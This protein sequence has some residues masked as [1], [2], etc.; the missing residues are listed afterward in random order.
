MRHEPPIYFDALSHIFGAGHRP[1]TKPPVVP[2]D[3][4]AVPVHIVAWGPDG[5][6]TTTSSRLVLDDG[7]GYDG[8]QVGPQVH[9]LL[10]PGSQYGWGAR[11]LLKAPEM[12]DFDQ[13]IAL[14]P[15]LNV[16][17]QP[18][19]VPLP[20]L[21]R[22]GQFYYQQGRPFTVIM[23]SAFRLFERLL[24]GEDIDPFLA[25]L[26]GEGFNSARIW[27]LNTSVGHIVPSEHAD[28]YQRIPEL[29]D[30]CAKRGIYPELTVFTQTRSLMPALGQQQDH[31]DQ[32][33]TALGPRFV[34]VEGV[35]ENDQ[36]DN[37]I[38]PSLRFWKPAGATFDLCRGS[39]GSDAWAVEPVLDSARYHSNDAN[40]WWR[41]QAHNPM[42]IANAFH[43]PCIANENTRPDHDS[44][45]HH[46][47]D[48]AAG[49]ALLHAGSCFHSQ[50]GKAAVPFS[51]QDRPCAQAFVQGAKS[52]DLTQREAPYI[53][54]TD[55][56]GPS[57]IRAYQ[58]GSQIVRIR[59]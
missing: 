16:T 33:V 11:L 55:L 48:A 46:H 51:A 37:A 12:A 31:Y 27:L 25:H 56:E 49:G 53:H 58:R 1:P 40:E 18:A 39:N 36:H 35:N 54:R 30:R 5:I 32:T 7:N 26:Q 45:P 19:F 15:D 20:V 59:A 43:V 34:F 24:S 13:R 8:A 50:S 42:E 47:E 2:P 6:L 57:V 38:D 22:R 9:F 52:M 44:D 3:P 28:F 10:P 17:L 14:G 41:R 29:V 23:A 4:P 21:E